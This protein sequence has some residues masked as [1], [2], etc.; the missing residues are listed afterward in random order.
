MSMD[1]LL[2]IGGASI[3]AALVCLLLRR[4]NP[5]GA[6]LLAG[7]TGLAVMLASLGILDRL[8]DLHSAVSKLL[9]ADGETL[10]SPI[11][12]SLA[13]CLITRF[14]AEFCKDASQHSVAAAV[15]MAGSACCLSAVMPLLVSVLKILGGL[16]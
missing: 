7:V 14:T 8:R 1:I 5:E 6:L 2:K 9:G 16:I 15:E 11:L 4:S 10:V 13:I 12:K 3:L